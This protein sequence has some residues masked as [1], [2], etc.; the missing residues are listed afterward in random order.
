MIR[1]GRPP[2]AG[3]G[4][5]R[6]SGVAGGALDR[7]GVAGV[8]LSAAFALTWLSIANPT[9]RTDPVRSAAPG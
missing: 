1:A 4:V 7:L 2:G 6:V 9:A 3:R 5:S 8:L